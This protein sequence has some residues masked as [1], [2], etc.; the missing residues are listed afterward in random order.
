[1]L[2]GRPTEVLLMKA[3]P[4]EAELTVAALRDAKIQSSLRVVEDGSQLP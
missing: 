3:N 1:L 4:S 2:I